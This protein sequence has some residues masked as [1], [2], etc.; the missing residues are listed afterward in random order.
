MN[1]SQLSA[2]I[3]KKN[4]CP[5]RGLAELPIL[6]ANPIRCRLAGHPKRDAA[7]PK[8]AIFRHLGALYPL[9]QQLAL[10]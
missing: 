10:L 9:H 5:P 7:P 1:F 2:K 6:P 4:I 3:H 8:A